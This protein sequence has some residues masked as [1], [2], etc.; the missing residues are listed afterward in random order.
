[1]A[2]AYTTG[3]ALDVPGFRHFVALYA[4]QGAGWDEV[5]RVEVE[6]AEFAAEGALA[7]A[8]FEPGEVWLVL[9]AGAGAHGGCVTVLRGDRNGLGYELSECSDLPGFSTVADV[10][11]A[12]AP[13]LIV[14]RSDA[15]VF[16]YACGVREVDYASA[17]AAS[18]RC[19]PTTNFRARRPRFGPPTAGS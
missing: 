8:A 15:S 3:Q 1:L 14:D 4:R 18:K 11:N 19:T 13:Q 17:A 2:A 5:G 16:C 6:E 10:A 9:T 12:G 7:Q